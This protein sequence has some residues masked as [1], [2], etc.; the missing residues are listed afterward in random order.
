MIKKLTPAPLTAFQGKN[1]L[2]NL[3]AESA[4]TLLSAKNVLVLA[5]QQMR[6]APGYTLVAN[7]GPGPIHSIYDFERTV[8]GVQ[9]IFVHSGPNI[10]AMNADGTN[11]RI[12]SSVESATPH[13]F[14]QNAFVSYSSNGTT[15]YRYVDKAGALTKYAWGISAP[16]TAPAISLSAGTLTL[17]YGRTYVFC[18]VSKYTDSLG[19]ERVHVGPPSPISAHT[20]PFN[21]GV[22]DLT[23]ITTSTD[24]QVTHIWIFATVDS[25]VNTSATFFFMAELTNG[26]TS[27][28]DANLDTA[29]DK[30]KLAPFDNNPV[31][32]SGILTTFQNRVVA[33]AGNQIRLSGFS[34]IT[35]GI[36]EESWPLS[37]FFNIPA[38]TRTA[39]AA[40]TLLSGTSL[41]VL[42][43]DAW[44]GYTGYDASTFTESDRIATPGCVGKFAICTTP[45]GIAW[46][47]PSKRLFMWTGNGTPTEI[48]SDIASSFPGTYG[49]EDLSTADLAT[50]QLQWYSF[51]KLHYLAAFCRTADAPDSGL[52][53]VQLWSIPVKG[54]QSSGEYTGSSGF[55]NQIG[56]I[57]QTDKIPSTSFTATSIVKVADTPYIY[58]GD[59]LGNIYRFPDGFEDNGQSYESNF[60][61]PWQLYG[62]EGTKRFHWIDLFVEAPASLLDSGGPLSNY[63]VFAACSASPTD[64]PKWIPLDLQL[65]PAP[66]GESQDA[67][68]ASMSKAGVNVGK[69]VRFLV[70]LPSD[71]N[72]Q[73]VLKLVTWFSPITATS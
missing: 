58:A 31:P 19:V 72:D 24:L 20:G 14:V 53:L 37:L 11:Q 63:K 12:L 17:T 10:V 52:N 44:Y 69:F 61:T 48:S 55:F 9:T 38:G 35:L 27:F 16:V 28:G 64:T 47:S 32:P 39:T 43:Q 67:L 42:T 7:V 66:S 29:L 33:V 71:A 59:A 23:D 41:G 6:R 45:F 46:L 73:V 25:P 22:V 21:S 1:T 70:V 60:S 54:S 26:T 49:M 36:P 57:F 34:E 13:V 4:S 40:T 18:Y 3:A 5:D 62:Y 2:Q 68:R 15:A 51:G 65:V 30:T 50:V 56:G 8:D